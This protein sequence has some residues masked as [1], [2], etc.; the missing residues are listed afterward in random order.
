MVK[1]PTL[2][3]SRKWYRVCDTSIEDDTC[4]LDVDSAEDLMSQA[5][6]VIPGESMIV[7]VAK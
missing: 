6:Y 2:S 7:L 5:R 1:I 3:D 4:I